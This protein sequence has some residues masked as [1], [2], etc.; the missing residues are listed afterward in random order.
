MELL[1]LSILWIHYNDIHNTPFFMNILLIS[2]LK[3]KEKTD[4]TWISLWNL[5]G[6]FSSKASTR[7]EGIRSQYSPGGGEMTCGFSVLIGGIL[8][9]AIAD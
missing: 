7:H 6:Q 1:L 9:P 5:L 4:H 2:I 3:N 8:L